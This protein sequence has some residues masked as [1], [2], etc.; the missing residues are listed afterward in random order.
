MSRRALAFLV[1]ALVISAGCVRLGF[2]QLHRLSERRAL[3]AMLASRLEGAPAPVRDV[4]R[5][6]AT[7]QYRRVTATG[8]YDFGNEFSLASRTRQGSPGVNIVTPIRIA[9]T[10]TAVLVNRGWVYAPDAMT[11]DLGRWREPEAATITGYLLNV[12]GAG[13]G[14]MTAPT[15]PRVLRRLDRDSLAGRFPYPIAPLLIVAT[16]AP[17][18]A[19]AATPARLAAPML[20]EGPHLGYAFQ[21]FA[22][23]LIGL[24]GGV[25]TVRADRRGTWRRS[26]VPLVRPSR[27]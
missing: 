6:P 11:A 22:F 26:A 1:F 8:T 25:V 20:D 5:E 23:A 27:Q 15:S 14:P 24:I 12:E 17:S 4:L 3:N 9:G 21:W 19:N 10:D 7:A 13:R 2:W 18:G 16:E